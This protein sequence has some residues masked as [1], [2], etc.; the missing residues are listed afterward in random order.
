[1]IFIAVPKLLYFV[2][3]MYYNNIECKYYYEILVLAI[4]VSTSRAK[5]LLKEKKSLKIK[6]SS[7]PY[8]TS[9]IRSSVPSMGFRIK[10]YIPIKSSANSEQN[11]F[12]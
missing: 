9:N 2:E 10:H 8:I 3:I 11:S 6:A 4:C 12:L 7:M 1:M 5:P